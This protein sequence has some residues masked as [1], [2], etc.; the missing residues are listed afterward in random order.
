MEKTTEFIKLV[1]KIVPENDFISIDQE[2][3]NG[4]NAC[5]LVCPSCLWKKKG[6][7][8]IIEKEYKSLCLEC[9]ACYQAC[10][11]DAIKF[12]FPPAGKG[13]IVK[14]G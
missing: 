9:G 2:K 5:I 8:A 10:T 3:C 14:Y 1:N 13:I 11:P 4:C 12:D 7:K 6:G